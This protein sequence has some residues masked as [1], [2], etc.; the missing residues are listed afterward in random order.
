MWYNALEAHYYNHGKVDDDDWKHWRLCLVW[1]GLWPL[2]RL[3]S[4]GRWIHEYS[5]QP[6]LFRVHFLDYKTKAHLHRTVLDTSRWTVQ[7]EIS[8]RRKNE[9]KTK[10][11]D[12]LLESFQHAGCLRSAEDTKSIARAPKASPPLSRIGK[13]ASCDR[14]H[15]KT[16][17]P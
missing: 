6:E 10:T 2:W 8:R 16:W 17:K 5:L 4:I 3:C 7:P 14:H 1:S 11:A 13:N 9:K 12:L 15:R